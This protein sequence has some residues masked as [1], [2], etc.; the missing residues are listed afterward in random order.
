MVVVGVLSLDT[1]VVD[2]P[3]TD[4]NSQSQSEGEPVEEVAGHGG[5]LLFGWF[6]GVVGRWLFPWC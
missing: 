6:E 3:G 4:V 2:C 5:F 1:V